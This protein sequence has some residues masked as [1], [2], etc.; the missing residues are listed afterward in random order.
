MNGTDLLFREDELKYGTISTRD[1]LAKAWRLLGDRPLPIIIGWVLAGIAT[2]LMVALFHEDLSTGLHLGAILGG[3]IIVIT[4]ISLLRRMRLDVGGRIGPRAPGRALGILAGIAVVPTLF[5]V[6]TWCAWL[7]MPVSG[8]IL[9]MFTTFGV[10]DFMAAARLDM[11]V[12][13]V[14]YGPLG[15][16][17]ASSFLFA[18]ACA[19]LDDKLGPIDSLRASWRMASGSRWQILR[20]SATCLALPATASVAAFALSI[21]RHS[22]AVFS[23]LPA[24]LW[25]LSLASLVLVL[26]PWLTCALTVL[27]VPLKAVDDRYVRRLAER[28]ASAGLS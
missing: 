22:A 20:I 5:R 6:T 13:A 14:L 19:L 16:G 25:S 3:A 8:G 2:G 28:K 15:F 23:G 9:Y 10:R 4:Q 27:L 17:L 11:L 21:L 12:G 18:P 26:G 7:A 24:V 1:C